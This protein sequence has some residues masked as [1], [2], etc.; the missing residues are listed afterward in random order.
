MPDPAGTSYHLNKWSLDTFGQP[1][2]EKL[3]ENFK[4]G[5]PAPKLEF[6][7]PNSIISPP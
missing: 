5:L 4:I 7:A 3:V 1:S 2:H 6:E